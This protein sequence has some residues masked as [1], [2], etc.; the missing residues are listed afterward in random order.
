MASYD[1]TEI[2]AE[3]LA[4]RRAKAGLCAACIRSRRIQ[5]DR[6]GPF[7]LCELHEGNPDFPKYPRL[8]VLYCSGYEV[9]S[10]AD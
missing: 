6:G 4:S 5:S 1:E 7:Y 9:K 8:P 3:Q 10:A 2:T